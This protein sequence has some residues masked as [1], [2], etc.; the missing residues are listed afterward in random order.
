MS[1]QLIT[2]QIS[3][4]TQLFDTSLQLISFHS[5]LG[6]VAGISDAVMGLVFLAAGTSV[7]DL[8]TSLIVAKQGTLLY[9][10]IKS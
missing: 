10:I 3:K 4:L 2:S 8:I 6:R 5:S 7:P 1:E 9:C